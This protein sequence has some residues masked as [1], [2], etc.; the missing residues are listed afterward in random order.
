M[1]PT[2]KET[3]RKLGITQKEM[4]AIMGMPQQAIARIESGVRCET[5]QH[6]AHLVTIGLVDEGV[7]IMHIDGSVNR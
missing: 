2:I 7:L 5:K 3:R 4:G 6:V 1:K